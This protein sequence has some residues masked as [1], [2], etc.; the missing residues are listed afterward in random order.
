MANNT[1]NS[2]EVHKV[3]QEVSSKIFSGE[4]PSGFRLIESELASK[5]GVSRTPVRLAIERLVSDDLAQHIPNKGAVVRNMTIEDIRGLLCVREVNEGLVARLA[6]QN[7]QPGDHTVLD[8][9]LREMELAL[10]NDDLHTYYEL[11]G[12]I[13]KYIRDMAKNKFLSDFLE[14]IYL[15]TYRYHINIM[16][17][18]GRATQSCKEHHDIV[19]AILSK[20]SALAENMMINHIKKISSFYNDE[21]NRVFFNYHDKSFW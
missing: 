10:K 3:Y 17:L 15:V 2:S 20:D 19:N 9:F 12:K 6:S 18:P 8:R 4:Y 5:F 16:L 11:S 21:R 14:K 13:H 1:T 7:V